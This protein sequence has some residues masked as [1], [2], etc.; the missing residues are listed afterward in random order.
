MINGEELLFVQV[1]PLG[2]IQQMD[3]KLKYTPIMIHKL[4]LI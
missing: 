4:P 3:E 2:A 1:K